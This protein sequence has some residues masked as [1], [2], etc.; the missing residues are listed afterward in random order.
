MTDIDY[1]ICNGVSRAAL[2]A[3]FR[4]F[5]LDDCNEILVVATKDSTPNRTGKGSVLIVFCGAKLD[6]RIWV[7][8]L[9]F[10]PV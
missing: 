4:R 6:T 7:L 10:F 9:S 1:S 8:A 5:Y 2:T 3:I